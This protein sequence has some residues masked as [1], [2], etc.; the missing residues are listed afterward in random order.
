MQLSDGACRAPVEVATFLAPWF[1]T[2]VP[3]QVAVAV[4]N[5]E[6]AQS[7]ISGG[8]ELGSRDAGAGSG[9]V[10]EVGGG[11]RGG[12]GLDNED[13]RLRGLPVRGHHAAAAPALTA[14]ITGSRVAARPWV[15]AADARQHGA[16]VR[17][18]AAT[19]RRF[20]A[21]SHCRCSSSCE[22]VPILSRAAPAGTPV[23]AAQ[24]TGRSQWPVSF[25]AD[26]TWLP[27]TGC[28]NAAFRGTAAHHHTNLPAP[29]RPSGGHCACP[30]RGTRPSWG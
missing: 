12:E 26:G 2:V 23:Q 19:A 6:V 14:R 9:N 28:R 24:H 17:T 8:A 15:D 18:A 3:A 21:V 11:S 13:S 30:S 29:T 22:G 10:S 5:R 16:T 25:C 4:A 27:C 7:D 20:G 1:G